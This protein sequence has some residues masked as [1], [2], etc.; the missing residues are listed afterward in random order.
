M[1]NDNECKNMYTY[2]YSTNVLDELLQRLILN[3]SFQKHALI[4]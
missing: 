1:L 3:L 2:I 4:S